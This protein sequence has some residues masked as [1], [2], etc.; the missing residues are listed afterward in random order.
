MEGM[1][2]MVAVAWWPGHAMPL[3]IGVLCV[4]AIS[5]RYYSAFLAAKVA[6]LDDARQTPAYRL[7][8]GK[9]Y[10]PTNKWVLKKAIPYRD[11]ISTSDAQPRPLEYRN[12]LGSDTTAR[13][14]NELAKDE[15]L[16]AAAASGKL[17]L[18]LAMCLIGPAF[19]TAIIC[20][21]ESRWDWR[22]APSFGITFLV[23]AAILVPILMWLERRTRGEFLVDA[24]RGQSDPLS[25][26]SYGE[27]CLEQDTVIF[28]VYTE[29]A[30]LGPRLVWNFI[31][32]MRG[33]PLVDATTRIEAARIVA[34]LF[35]SDAACPIAG[36]IAPEHPRAAVARAIRYLLGKE[37]IDLSARRDRI[38][39]SSRVRQRLTG[40]MK[41]AERAKRGR[42]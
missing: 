18:G 8:D 1:A 26:S 29:I 7:E 36:L 12:P 19:V 33:K 40:A 23:V 20:D 2:M 5:Y 9:N 28:K 38:W 25:A 16:G 15:A 30:L 10:E 22:S 3:M 13:I 17:A 39:L 34:A 42:S 21:I 4:M 6:A 32:W 11:E 24:M 41:I 14:A 37:W 31:D 27:F 35:A